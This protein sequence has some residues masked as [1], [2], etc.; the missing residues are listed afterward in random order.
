MHPWS[1]FTPEEYARRRT[2]LYIVLAVVGVLV[3]AL[4]VVQV[5]LVFAPPDLSQEEVAA[6]E[7]FFDS[8]TDLSERA[9]EAVGAFQTGL[10]DERKRLDAEKAVT[11]NVAGQLEAAAVA[12]T[13]EESASGT[14]PS[15]SW[16]V[17]APV[18]ED[19]PVETE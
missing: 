3:V 15:S 9:G 2:S 17:D 11:A 13:E 5:R 19:V 16:V 10:Q 8:V 18:A 6:T 1:K 7:T 12:S 14:E 4:F